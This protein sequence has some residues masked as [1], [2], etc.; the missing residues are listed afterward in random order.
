MSKKLLD[1]FQS[2][3]LSIEERIAS[4][5]KL[6]DKF[7]RIKQGEY[8]PADNRIDPISILEEQGKTRIPDL[9][10]SQ[11]CENAYFTLCISSRWC[12]YYGV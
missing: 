8:K 12:S 4:G 1:H 2:K 10:P 5:K 3:Q 7:P 9:V 11:V 6:R